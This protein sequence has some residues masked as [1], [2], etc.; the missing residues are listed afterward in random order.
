MGEEGTY[1]FAEKKNTAPIFVGS[2]Q[3]GNGALALAENGGV[4]SLNETATTKTKYKKEMVQEPFEGE[5]AVYE[6]VMDGD[7]K[8][9]YSK[10][11]NVEKDAEF[12]LRRGDGSAIYVAGVLKYSRKFSA[13][14]G[15]DITTSLSATVAGSAAESV[16]SDATPPG[17]E[18]EGPVTALSIYGT[19][20]G[21][22]KTGTFATSTDLN[23]YRE[24]VG[25]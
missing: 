23:A 7:P 6:W 4:S 19:V 13:K 25:L 18:D 9:T 8:E 1:F 10:S 15:Q 21:T 12:V 14:A 5:P 24:A 3:S 20:S 22:I 16:E 17:S 2:S 11:S